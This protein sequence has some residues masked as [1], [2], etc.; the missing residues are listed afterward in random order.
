VC[1]ADPARRNQIAAD[2]TITTGAHLEG[3]LVRL[4]EQGAI[5]EAGEKPSTLIR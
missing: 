4:L 2:D 3:E 1:R 5:Q